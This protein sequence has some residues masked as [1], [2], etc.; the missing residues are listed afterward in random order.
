M[1]PLTG[2]T[3]LVTGGSRGIGAAIAAR[4]AGDGA[5]VALTYRSSPDR[6]TGVVERIKADGGTAI[7]VPAAMEDPQ[8][9]RDA[10]AATVE[11]Y[12]GLDVVVNNAG[13]FPTGVIDELTLA[14]FEHAVA[15]HVRAV[16][17]AVHAA[18]PTM[19]AGGR[20]ISIGSSLVERV[21]GPGISLYAMSK[22]A[23]VGFTKGLARDLG[24]RG[25]TAVVVHPGSTD[26]EMNPADAPEAEAERAMTALGR[27]ATTDDIAALVAYLAGPGGAYITGTTITVDGGAT[28]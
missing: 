25:I 26:T 18:L 12:G 17:A 14:D 20:I 5:R 7:A 15:I 3:A 2:K 8:Q 1:G 13:A 27:Y 9:V 4:L 16:F 10:V 24:P 19:G 6:A 28:A 21:P 11:A 23:L 22:S